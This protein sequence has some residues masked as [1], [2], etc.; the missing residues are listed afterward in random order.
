MRMRKSQNDMHNF[1]RR[2]E[3]LWVYLNA[4]IERLP[5]FHASHASR[6][7]VR[8]DHGQTLQPE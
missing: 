1:V 2:G 8:G 7:F 3:I 6:I 4:V 5:E